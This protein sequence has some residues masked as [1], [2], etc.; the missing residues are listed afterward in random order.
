MKLP[1]NPLSL[2]GIAA[3]LLFGAGVLSAQTHTSSTPRPSKPVAAAAQNQTSLPPVPQS[4]FVTPR[5]PAEGRD[6]FFP[7]STRPYNA[8]GG[9]DGHPNQPAAHAAPVELR[10]NGISGMP[11]HLLA[12]VN[13]RTFGVGDEGDIVS[14]NSRVHIR[15]LAI[16]N[17]SVSVQV[18]SE[19]RELRIRSNL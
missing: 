18:G 6:P 17:D 7:A 19:R 4:V 13:N 3:G 8:P 12:I 15:C 11:G 2:I 1:M 16:G 5:T 14:G 10:L 9:P